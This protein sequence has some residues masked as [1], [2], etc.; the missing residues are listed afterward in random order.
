MICSYQSHENIVKWF[1]NCF[2]KHSREDQMLQF[3]EFCNAVETP[4]VRNIL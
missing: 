1:E 3:E 4:G 2:K